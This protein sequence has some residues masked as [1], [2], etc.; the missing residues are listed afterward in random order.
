VLDL[1]QAPHRLAADALGWRVGAA[2]LRVLGL[3][4]AQL[5]EQRV[6]LVVPDDRVV[7]NVVAVVVEGELLAQLGGALGR[8]RRR[9]GAHSTSEA[10]GDT[11]RARS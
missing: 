5:V 11:R 2:Q 4:P 6:V 1:L 7:E 9:R 3:Q 8:G 10:A